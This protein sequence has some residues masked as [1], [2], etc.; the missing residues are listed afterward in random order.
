[1]S[2]AGAGLP[3]VAAFTL[4]VPML[5]TPAVAA[6]EPMLPVQPQLA[7]DPPQTQTP[8]LVAGV[9]F[10]PS[11]DEP[12]YDLYAFVEDEDD[13]L[14]RTDTPVIAPA[15]DDDEA[16]SSTQ[17]AFSPN[18]SQIVF[19]AQQSAGAEWHLMI[20]DVL[21]AAEGPGVSDVR[22]LDYP[23]L[24]GAAD[25]Q[26]A[27][28]P[29]GQ[30]LAFVREYPAEGE[31]G[32]DG[33][34]VQI[35]DWDSGTLTELPLPAGPAVTHTDSRWAAAPTWSPDGSGL[36]VTGNV[37]EQPMD[38]FGPTDPDTSST[39][40]L[41]YYH[42]DTDTVHHVTVSEEG[43]GGDDP[44]NV[45]IEARTAAWSPDPSIVAVA[46]ES[47]SG[48]WQLTLPEDLPPAGSNDLVLAEGAEPIDTDIE[49]PPLQDLAWDPDG[50]ALYA[51]ADQSSQIF[52]IATGAETATVYE[53]N[54]TAL[55][56]LASQPYSD[57][58]IT[59]NLPSNPTAG[60]TITAT[61]EVTNAGPSP[62][63]QG[64]VQLEVPASTTVDAVP[65][66]CSEPV[67]QVTTCALDP[68][69]AGETATLEIDLTLDSPGAGTVS[70]TVTSAS[71]DPD[72]AENIATATMVVAAPPTGSSE[73]IAFSMERPGDPSVETTNTESLDLVQSVTTEPGEPAAAAYRVLAASVLD[74]VDPIA[75]SD[76]GLGPL[77]ATE[78]S[79]DYSADGSRA[80]FTRSADIQYGYTDDQRLVIADVV[81]T[82]QPD[83]GESGDLVHLRV[84]E[85][86]PGALPA[87]FTGADRV[88]ATEPV[89]SPDGTQVAFVRMVAANDGAEL[90]RIMLLDPATDA[91]TSPFDP[92]WLA[93]SAGSDETDYLSGRMTSPT[94]SPDG[95]ALIY[96][97]QGPGDDAPVL[98]YL[99]LTT[100]I[101]HA[102]TL[103]EDGSVCWPG[104]GGDFCQGP[105]QGFEP[106]WSP[107]GDR[108]AFGYYASGGIGIAVL[109]L[110]EASTALAQD[111]DANVP[112]PIAALTGVDAFIPDGPDGPPANSPAWSPDGARIAAAVGNSDF[113]DE[114]AA[115]TLATGERATMFQAADVPT[116]LA[117]PEFEPWSDVAVTIPAASGRFSTGTSTPV[118]VTIANNGPSPARDAFAAI[119]LPRGAQPGTPPDECTAD[120]RTLTCELPGPIAAGADVEL[121][122]PVTFADPGEA[123]VTATVA[124]N[125]IDT[126]AGNDSAARTFTVTAP[127]DDPSDPRDGP[128]DRPGEPGAPAG[129]PGPVADVQV[130]ISLEADRAWLGGT[131]LPAQIT[132][133]NRGT[134]PAR[135][136]QLSTAL[137]T[138]VLLLDAGSC[139]LTGACDLG[140]LP[141]GGQVE[142]TLVAQPTAVGQIEMTASATS[143]TRDARPQNNTDS[144]S[145]EAVQAELRLLPAVAEPGEVTLLYGVDL[146]PD[147]EIT[148]RWSEGITAAHRT[149]A[150]SEDG[151][152]RAPVLIIDGDQLGSRDLQ[153]TSVA[154]TVFGLEAPPTMLVVP[155]S[156]APP[157]F[158]GRS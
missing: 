127:P 6:P 39:G 112:L 73:R 119:T 26:P 111:P 49:L 136:V 105:V 91:I 60:T 142:V 141:R 65:A 29:D 9:T 98:Q 33:P 37:G 5:A 38:A 120:G 46:P 35:L 18:G 64:Q 4:V 137:P 3:A 23:T 108:V 133:T 135:G 54:D 147:A 94:W 126:E 72:S 67:A 96:G 107:G 55:L 78:D 154:G 102:L 143:T 21:P 68:I 17:P 150:A 77:L 155:Q 36:L 13:A 153:V 40:S 122:I 139:P 57:L 103:P 114:I 32:A 19:S 89:W 157:N 16:L 66:G 146:P 30:H 148:V 118:T 158:L 149:L 25:Y 110:A 92:A 20:G 88:S 130:Q 144:A 124:T 48:A 145:F 85:D 152:L 8:W 43:C 69:A 131:G 1:M 125:S 138:G 52:R 62:S 70:A 34:Q 31:R 134:A 27:W 12:D 97:W 123:R 113:V 87:D 50:S 129:Q 128:T 61:A 116:D 45:P 76:S 100:G 53:D 79:I 22:A 86:A 56:G 10:A 82:R 93:S 109:T 121:V 15:G 99:P 95:D 83:L 11:A 84:V 71:P 140:T 104:F 2:R 156:V 58:G 132:V 28:S 101:P 81:G 44:C 41:W 117:R 80:V 59:L 47:S 151:T 14:E 42:L 7:L 74:E 51:T 75:G 115:V 63:R 106:A 90:G 24:T